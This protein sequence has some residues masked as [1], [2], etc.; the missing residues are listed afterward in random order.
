MPASETLKPCPFCGGT[1][2]VSAR[3]C[4]RDTPYDA[5]DRAFPQARCR[6]CHA[7]APGEDWSGRETAI[8]AWNRRADSPDLASLRAEVERLTKDRDAIRETSAENLDNYLRAHERATRLDEA[9]AAIG[10]NAEF[11]AHTGDE[12]ARETTPDSRWVYAPWVEKVVRQARAATAPQAPPK[13]DEKCCADFDATIRRA[14]KAPPLPE[15]TIRLPLEIVEHGSGL[16]TYT[17]AHLRTD[18]GEAADW[19]FYADCPSRDT[20]EEIVRALTALSPQAPSCST[21]KGSTVIVRR[22]AD[23][24]SCC[25]PGDRLAGHTSA[26]PSCAPQAPTR[27]E[28]ETWRPK[29]GDV[30]R[31]HGGIV[32]VAGE[33]YASVKWPNG[34]TYTVPLSDLEPAPRAGG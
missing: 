18:R 3:T 23:T 25:R 1:A 30:V 24:F 26:C 5:A 27:E 6:T 15:P 32:T 9:L 33:D 2:S 17:L 11:Y 22:C 10:K 21:C 28:P 7:T 20:A 14:V 29:V 4:N 19:Y 34:E 16:K 8:A 13:P 12:A 31:R